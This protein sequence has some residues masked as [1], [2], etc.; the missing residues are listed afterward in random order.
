MVPISFVSDHVETLYEIDVQYGDL[1]TELGLTLR[2]SDS[3]NCDK[4]FIKALAKLVVE[5][6]RME[7]W[8]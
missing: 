6:C 4:D 7:Q 5:T 2:R 8:L 3:L 1:A